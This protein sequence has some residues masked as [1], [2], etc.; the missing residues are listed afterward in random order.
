MG[1][2]GGVSGPTGTTVESRGRAPEAGLSGRCCGAETEYWFDVRSAAA[3]D[4]DDDEED[5]GLSAAELPRGKAEVG[6]AHGAGADS[7]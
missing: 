3:E 4:D 2:A 5:M 7:G 1:E 6:T